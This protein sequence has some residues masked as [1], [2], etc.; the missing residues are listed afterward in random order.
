MTRESTLPPGLY[1][2]LRRGVVFSVA[3]EKNGTLTTSVIAEPDESAII[4]VSDVTSKLIDMTPSDVYVR[5]L[6]DGLVGEMS[7]SYLKKFAKR[8]L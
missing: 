2:L 5:V 6:V 7:T 3:C 4:M 1:T 8:M